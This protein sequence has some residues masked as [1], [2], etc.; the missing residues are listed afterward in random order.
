MGYIYKIINDI[1]DK[2]YIGQTI[3]TIEERWKE[4][5]KES[6]GIL[7]SNHMLCQ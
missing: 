3:R 2:I 6:N 7:F 1:N 5:L 4:H